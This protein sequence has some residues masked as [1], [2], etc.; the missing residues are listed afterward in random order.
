M[1]LKISSDMTVMHY[2]SNSQNYPGL[3]LSLYHLKG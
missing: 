1:E 3:F 2:T